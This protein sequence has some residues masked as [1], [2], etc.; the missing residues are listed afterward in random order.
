MTI[1]KEQKD[2]FVSAWYDPEKGWR[3]FLP[4]G[5]EVPALC[6][7]SVTVGDNWN[8][9]LRPLP[10]ITIEMPCLIVKDKPALK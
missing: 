6:Q 4:S 2:D 5:E 9:E 3:I 7:A 10:V 1:D 8:K